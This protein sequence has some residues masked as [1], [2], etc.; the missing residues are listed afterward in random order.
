MSITFKC[1]YTELIYLFPGV[2]RVEIRGKAP[3]RFPSILALVVITLDER[4]VQTEG[5]CVEQKVPIKHNDTTRVNLISASMAYTRHRC[6]KFV[7]T[8]SRKRG[9]IT[10]RLIRISPQGGNFTMM[11]RERTGALLLK[12]VFTC[13]IAL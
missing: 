8:H 9:H 10:C 4:K 11:P 1:H 12:G 5:Y 2:E 7:Q 3:V 13:F 6:K